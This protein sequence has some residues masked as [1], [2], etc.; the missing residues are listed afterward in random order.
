MRFDWCAVSVRLV[1]S[2]C[3]GGASVARTQSCIAILEKRRKVMRGFA[4]YDQRPIV[5]PPW[6]RQARP[7]MR[8]R[9]PLPLAG[10]AARPQVSAPLRPISPTTYAHKPPCQNL[11][12]TSAKWHTPPCYLAPR[13]KMANRRSAFRDYCSIPSIGKANATPT[14]A[15]IARQPFSGP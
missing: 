6:G 7:R 10:N 11:R 13:S 8:S 5:I 14:Q 9:Y 15:I 1:C 3:A 2:F 4:A 12:Q